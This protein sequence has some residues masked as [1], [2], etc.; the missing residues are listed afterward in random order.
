MIFPGRLL[1]AY[2]LTG[3]AMSGRLWM[4]RIRFRAM[5]LLLL[6]AGCEGNGSAVGPDLPPENE[7]VF[8]CL[9]PTSQIFDGGPGKDGIP[10]V[11][12]PI[13]VGPED[14][15]AS[16][17]DPDDRIIGVVVNGRAVA[18]PHRMGWMHEI[19]NLSHP[20]VIAVTYCPLT[21][22]SMVFDRSVVNGDEFGVSGLLFRTN[23][24]MYNRSRQESLWSQMGRGVMC[25]TTPGIA[26]P[27][28]P[29]FEMTWEG[30]RTLYPETLVPAHLIDR[31]QLYGLYRYPYGDYEETEDIL[32]PFPDVDPRRPH[33]ERVLGIPAAPVTLPGSIG[34]GP[35]LDATSGDAIAFPFGEL[36]R[37][38]AIA[39]V[40]AEAGRG[41]VVVFWSR[42]WRG[43]AAFVP[44]VDGQ[45]L[46]FTVR[47]GLVTD[48]ETGSVWR[49]DGL[50]ERGP[51]EGRALM[52]VADAYVAFWFAWAEFNQGTG[53]WMAG[54]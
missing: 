25:G 6:V 26:L 17:L 29:A 40:H 1:S 8:E 2:G 13:M 23:L 37:A 27:M 3:G 46:N 30:W 38:G 28:F 45:H 47:D 20:S 14:P 53:V 48:E 18:I 32:F 41:P 44:E 42:A 52:P 31:G 7:G 51:L 36:D 34:A 12:D 22:S 11:T 24:I 35:P 39:A 4:N 19:F 49:L 54:R 50:A 15:A 9:V 43:A 10:A 21:G 33:K 16:W 5:F